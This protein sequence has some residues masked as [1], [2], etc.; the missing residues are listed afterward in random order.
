MPGAGGFGL[1]GP[2][3]VPQPPFLR[4]AGVLFHISAKQQLSAGDAADGAAACATRPKR[5]TPCRIKAW[6]DPGPMSAPRL[7]AAGR[8]GAGSCKRGRPFLGVIGV[9]VG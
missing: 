8:C 2:S 9:N 1:R 7:G 3:R 6:R 4:G 5:T